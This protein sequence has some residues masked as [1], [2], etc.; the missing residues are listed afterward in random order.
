[1]EHVTVKLSAE[2][3]DRVVQG[4]TKEPVFMEGGDLA[5][6]VKPRATVGGN[7]SVVFTFTVLCSDGS[8]AR[9]QCVT[10]A[11]LVKQ[12]AAAIKGWEEGG[13]I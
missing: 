6:Y 2:D 4:K 8:V 1:M 13:F 7:A 3:Y 9:A 10:T 12:I 11:A 5:V